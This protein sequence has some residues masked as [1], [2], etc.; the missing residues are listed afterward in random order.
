[1]EMALQST[2]A[3]LRNKKGLTLIELL[4]IIVIIGIITAI[5]IPAINTTISKS[6]TNADA[7]TDQLYT[8][9]V[10]RYATEENL[11]DGTSVT[12]AEL[13]T[14]GYLTTDLEWVKSENK[15]V[16]ATIAISTTGVITVTLSKT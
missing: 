5:A 12:P 2:K 9:A 11:T 8:D 15:K 4:A 1:M 14:K 7:A 3:T 6:K 16:K 10:I 13:K